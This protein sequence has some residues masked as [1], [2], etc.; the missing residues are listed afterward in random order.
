[1]SAMQLKL[2]NETLPD[3]FDQFRADLAGHGTDWLERRRKDALRRFKE[4][5]VPT[6]RQEDWKYTDIRPLI[7]HE[8]DVRGLAGVGQD[9]ASHAE[10]TA[11]DGLDAIRL[12]VV[13]G[14][15][16][17]ER[18]DIGNLP[19]G[20]SVKSLAEILDDD[21]AAVEPWLGKALPDD[22]HGFSALNDMF[23]SDGV[24]LHVEEGA[25]IET[26]IEVVFLV[27]DGEVAPL[28]QPRNL[29][30]V[31]EGARVNIVERYVG[32]DD[33]AYL[34][35]TISEI[36]LAPRAQLEYT[37]LQEE[38]RRA[39]HVGGLFARQGADSRGVFNTV[40][41]EGRLTRN[42]VRIYLDEPGAE[43]SLNGLALGGG[44]QHI[45]NHT[46]IEHRVERCVSREFYKAVLADRARAVFHGR[47]VVHP[48]AQQTDSEQQNQNLLLSR[49][50]E[51][52][53]KPQL[54][55]YADD[56]KCSHGATVG[57]LDDD[58]V[59]YLRSRGIDE[60]EARG[61]LTIA[62]ADAA[63]ANIS[64]AALRDHVDRCIR[65]KLGA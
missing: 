61:L 4:R 53:T 19:E 51:V 50:A 15:F 25:Q 34:N 37:R 35:N 13:D 8:Y 30:I 3:A 33:T 64:N 16:D 54:E 26:I 57:Q 45:D 27:G 5:G 60:S 14:R 39:G 41:L 38:G 29:L 63:I 52:D 56:V 31:G 43:C 46:T 55:I 22:G 18:S 32:G 2:T 24:V 48:D 12:A 40:T 20:V 23:L 11:I 36:F 49:D 9:T 17:A 62:F 44:R 65:R 58:A 21:A 10:T 28:V 6:L 7:S 47:I 59:F 42:D 1:M